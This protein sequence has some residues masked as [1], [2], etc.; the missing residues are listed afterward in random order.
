M[1]ICWTCNINQIRELLFV[2]HN[3]AFVPQLCASEVDC[4][5]EH[6]CVT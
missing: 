3:Y 5:V 1:L 6:L 2:K 4:F